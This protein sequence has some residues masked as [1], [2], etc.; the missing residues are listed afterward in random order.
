MI[1]QFEGYAPKANKARETLP[2]GGYVARIM[3]AKVIDYGYGDV[4]LIAFD[5][6]EGEYKG[7]FQR[8]FDNQNQEDKK[9]RGTYRLNIPKDDGSEKDGWAKNTFNGVMFAI[10]DSNSGYSWNWDEKSLKGK[11]IGVLYRNKEWEF[12]GR[13]GWTTECCTMITAQDVRDGKFKM[14]KDKPLKLAAKSIN[15]SADEKDYVEIVSDDELP[16]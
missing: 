8:D 12:D 11:T 1:K 3:D 16:F 13:S 4:L 2:A 5:I 14:P 6:S 9:W 10:E 15:I 7:F